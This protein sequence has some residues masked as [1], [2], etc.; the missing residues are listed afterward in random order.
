MVQF[1]VIMP[2]YNRSH[3]LRTTVDSVLAQSH[4]DFELIIVDDGSTDNTFDVMQ[5]YGDRIIALRQDNAGPAAARNTALHHATGQYVAFLDSDDLW[6][7]WTLKHFADAIETHHQPPLVH[8]MPTAFTDEATLPQSPTAAS[9]AQF[10]CFFDYLDSPQ[11]RWTGLPGLV[12]QREH[13]N[14]I[15]GFIEQRMNHEDTDLLFRLGD[16]GPYIQISDVP[17]VG[18][19]THENNISKNPHLLKAGILSMIHTEARNQYPGGK[20]WQTIR[21]KV[22]TRMARTDS[23]AMLQAGHKNHA[24]QLYFASWS[25]QCQQRRLRYLVGY[26]WRE[27]TSRAIGPDSPND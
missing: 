25:M 6:F 8:A 23:I 13:L 3:Y 27:L 1:S 11:V 7:P 2:A 5:A 19:R 22:I 12:V 17:M 14:R 24:R 9:L 26:W 18:Y 21:R 16:L 15:G 4:D 20:T 10:D